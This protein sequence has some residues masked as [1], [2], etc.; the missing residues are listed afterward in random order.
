VIEGDGR[1]GRVRRELPFEDDREDGRAKTNRPVLYR[2]WATRAELALAALRHSGFT[3]PVDAPDTGSLRGDLLAVLREASDKRAG[4]AAQFS[5][6]IAEHYS[7]TGTT[8]E[9]LRQEL[10]ANRPSAL[11]CVLDR[12]VARGEVDP[13]RLT[14]RLRRL[15]GDLMRH[16]LL[17]NLRPMSDET[18]TE[19]V[20][21]VLLPLL[22]ART[23]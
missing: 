16:E 11:D 7:E 21:E 10:F 13:A 4:V 20:D 18:I 14:P 8:L 5:V 3:E 1:V 6:L 9:Q 19:L 15:P 17:T 22:T 2:R 12:A 23:L